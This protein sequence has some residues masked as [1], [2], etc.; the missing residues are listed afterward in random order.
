[1][2]M[3]LKLG[4]G[5]FDNGVTSYRLLYYKIS[6]VAKVKAGDDPDS[7]EMVMIHLVP[8]HQPDFMGMVDF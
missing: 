8:G 4:W 2:K 1:M 3:K 7:R 5:R 6:T